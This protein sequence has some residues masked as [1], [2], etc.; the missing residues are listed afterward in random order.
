M[1][2]VTLL[3]LGL[4][5]LVAALLRLINLG[6]IPPGVYIDEASFGYNA[7]SLLLTGKDEWGQ[8]W[9]IFLR[10]FGTYTSVLYIYL[11]TM[12]IKLMDLSIL[13]VRLPAA[14]F[15]ILI[16]IVTYLIF[17]YS[18]K[19]SFQALVLAFIVS[20]SPWA[21]LYSRIGLELTFALFLVLVAI[22]LALLIE[23]RA[24]YF[25]LVSLIL[26]VSVYAYQALRIVSPLFL[27]GIIYFYKDKLL[28]KKKILI[29]GIILFALLQ[30]PQ[31]TVL[32]TG[33][34]SRRYATQTFLDQSF[35]S[36]YGKYQGVPGGEVVYYLREFLAQFSAYFS[37]KNLFF[38]PDDQPTRSM[39]YLSVFYSWM[40][41]PFIFGIPIFWR[42][43]NSKLFKLLMLLLIISPIP[44]SVTRD[45]F[46]TSRILPF[47]WVI[48]III[49]LGV[50]NFFERVR[51]NLI[52]VTLSLV[53]I[54]YS[55]TSLYSSYFILMPHIRSSDYGYEYK[56]LVEALQNYK[57]KQVVVISDKD[58]PTYIM[59]AFGKKFDPYKI[60]EQSAPRVAEGYYTT[61][62]FDERYI[63]EN[64]EVK[65]LDWG[66]ADKDLIL[67]GPPAVLNSYQVENHKLSKVFDIKGLDGKVLLVGYQTDLSQD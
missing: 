5:I 16:P 11:L 41:I 38:L 50:V 10:S 19:S 30:I 49:G 34:G 21:I 46:Y 17:R 37:P 24:I 22:Y 60:Q 29:V 9:P 7:Y 66:D 14:I 55:F 18:F 56:Q 15:G 32:G 58:Y 63:L 6:S 48:T 31:L 23:K 42:R 3:L 44:A 28:L 2:K 25:L 51:S 35:Y 26:G 36:S 65:Q 52:K 45:P 43:R 57:H 39:I 13:S 64:I 54:L 61:A 59:L 8:S 40:I 1:S 62:D 20:I 67:V 47:L 33:G 27:I 12:P 4:I 53:V